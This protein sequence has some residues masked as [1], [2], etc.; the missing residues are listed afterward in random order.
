MSVLNTEILLSFQG[1]GIAIGVPLHINWRN[2]VKHLGY[3]NLIFKLSQLHP[4]DQGMLYT[5]CQ[6]TNI[7]SAFC[8][9]LS[10]MIIYC[11]M[12]YFV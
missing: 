2:T 6:T 1:F 12:L 10:A 8:S 5:K 3:F 7:L 4:C 9:L 11:W